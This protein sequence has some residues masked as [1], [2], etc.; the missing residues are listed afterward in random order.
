VTTPAPQTSN[1][2]ALSDDFFAGPVDDP[3]SDNRYFTDTKQ[4]S[5]QS[6]GAPIFERWQ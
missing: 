4:P 3:G 1:W 6:L 5:N 2:K